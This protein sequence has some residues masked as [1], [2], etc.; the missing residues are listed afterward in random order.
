MMNNVQKHEKEIQALGD[1]G[2]A[3][4]EAGNNALMMAIADTITRIQMA[5]CGR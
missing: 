5:G 1:R 4:Q 2:S 3:A